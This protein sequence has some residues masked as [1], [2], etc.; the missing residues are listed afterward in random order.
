MIIKDWKK[1]VFTIPNMF[2][3]FVFRLAANRFWV[4]KANKNGLNKKDLNKCIV[5]Q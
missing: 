5:K 1:D 3:R 4:S 2:P